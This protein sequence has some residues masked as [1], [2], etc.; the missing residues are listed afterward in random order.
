MMKTLANQ[1]QTCSCSDT[2]EG[3]LSPYLVVNKQRFIQSVSRLC[4]HLGL[5]ALEGSHLG[6]LY[7]AHHQRLGGSLQRGEGC[8]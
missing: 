7:H 1:K 6:C 2:T 5:S 3:W 4:D 8:T